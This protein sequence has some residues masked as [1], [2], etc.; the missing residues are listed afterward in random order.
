MPTPIVGA[1]PTTPVDPVSGV[2]AWILVKPRLNAAGQ[3]E[4][5]FELRRDDPT[6]PNPYSISV[7]RDGN[8][9]FSGQSGHI[10]VKLK[11]VA[12]PWSWAT[13]PNGENFVFADDPG[14]A[15][16]PVN[17]SHHQ[18]KNVK[19][20]GPKV[21]TFNYR[22]RRKGKTGRTLHWVSAWGMYMSN[23]TKTYLLDPIISNGGN[24]TEEFLDP[25]SP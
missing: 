17:A 21:I 5:D 16:T 2:D 13:G 14:G 7:E 15:L 12:G 9:I 10:R 25:A 3:L 1:P 11:I 24:P 8:L 19:T 18:I 6:E 4:A 22:N 20:N 23:G